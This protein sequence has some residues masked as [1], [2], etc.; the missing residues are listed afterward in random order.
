M[1]IN[2]YYGV[3][4]SGGGGGPTAASHFAGFP[5]AQCSDG[6]FGGASDFYGK[7]YHHQN[8]AVHQLVKHSVANGNNNNNT[9]LHDAVSN[10]EDGLYG[11]RDCNG[12]LAAGY[13]SAADAAGIHA[14][15]V[16]SPVPGYPAAYVNGGRDLGGAYRPG[17]DPAALTPSPHRPHQ[18]MPPH[19]QRGQWS[20]SSSVGASSY[21]VGVKGGDTTTASDPYKLSPETAHHVAPSTPAPA[22]THG[23]TFDSG[24][25][26]SAS[27]SPPPPS[28][29]QSCPARL[30]QQPST[31]QQQPSSIS[32]HQPIPYYPWMGVVGTCAHLSIPALRRQWRH[33]RADE[34]GGKLQ[35][36]QK[37]HPNPN[38]NHNPF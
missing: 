21:G 4:A 33:P 20:P 35:I 28:S 8:G 18:S 23:A 5:F 12:K 25:P 6:G 9:G 2:P 24:D 22:A 27:M 17:D 37:Y 14:M 38:S 19:A 29:V 10:N 30:P 26:V 16:G 31:Q 1:N 7:H 3:V 11:G 32:H 34:I 13:G 15:H 36:R